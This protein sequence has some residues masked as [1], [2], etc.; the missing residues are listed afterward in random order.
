M[1]GEEGLAMLAS[2]RVAVFGLGGVGSA[3]AEALVR[4]GVGSF[5]FVDKDEV[6]PSNLNR[7]AIAFVSTIGRPKAEVMSAMAKDIN[8]DANVDAVQEFVRSDNIDA[9]LVPFPRPDYIVDAFDTLSVK[10]EIM[11]YAQRHDI[12]LVSAMGGANKTDPTRLEFA[13]LSDTR[14]CP[15]C[16]EMRKIARDRGIGDVTV[17]FSDEPP[18]KVPAKEDAERSQKTELGTMSYFPPTMGLMI[19]GYVIQQLLR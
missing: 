17:L 11:Q 15:L 18:V 9:L 19:A 10:A 2:S 5:L 3:C 4:G 14:V 6:E 16:R 12:P 13:K 8:P 7:Q 1:I